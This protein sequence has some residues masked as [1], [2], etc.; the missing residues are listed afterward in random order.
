ME[1]EL[2]REGDDRSLRMVED[3]ARRAAESGSVGAKPPCESRPRP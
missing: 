3:L 1:T 2:V